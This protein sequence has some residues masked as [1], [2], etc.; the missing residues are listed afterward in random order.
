M[1]TVDPPWRHLTGEAEGRRR[2]HLVLY[3]IT[4]SSR[5]AFYS[6][7]AYSSFTFCSC[8]VLQKVHKV[9]SLHY[10]SSKQFILIL[11]ETKIRNVRII[12]RRQPPR[13][14]S[15]LATPYTQR[16]IGTGVHI[17]P[18]NSTASWYKCKECTCFIHLRSRPQ[19]R[20]LIKRRSWRRAAGSPGRSGNICSTSDGTE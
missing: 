15:Y 17:K 2:R 7:D 20:R 4:A 12:T 9:S 13:D 10:N 19:V 14:S 16:C 3:L 11:N 18:E 6:S 5:H 1:E 8:T